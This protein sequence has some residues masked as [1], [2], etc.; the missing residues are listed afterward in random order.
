MDDAQ[1]AQ[2]IQNQA[3]DN[4]LD[5]AVAEAEAGLS[6]Y[7]GRRKGTRIAELAAIGFV[8]LLLVTCYVCNNF[9]RFNP[10]FYTDKSW[11]VGQTLMWLA[12]FLSVAFY[13]VHESLYLTKTAQ[14]SAL[15]EALKAKKRSLDQ[16]P[17]PV[18]G[19]ETKDR[20]ETGDY[21]DALVRINVENLAGYYSLVKVHTNKSFLVA[22]AAGIAGF[23]LLAAGLV[24]GFVGKGDKM[25]YISTGAGVVTEFIA[26]VFFYLYNR[27]IQQMKEYHDSLLD[28][29]NVLLALKLVDDTE[30]SDDRI[31]MIGQMLAYLLT[32]RAG[33]GGTPAT[34]PKPEPPSAADATS[35]MR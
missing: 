1:I 22:I 35:A 18:T 31:K 23:V 10:F 28:V 34:F 8:V 30:E 15:L 4:G 19:P 27:T 21:F 7:R 29:Q 2:Q 24:L 20:R 16:L 6:A 12:A 9:F 26:S 11:Q 17:P 13:L 5:S 33:D 25:T 14:E 32:K 3:D